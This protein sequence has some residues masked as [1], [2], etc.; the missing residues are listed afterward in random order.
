MENKKMSKQEQRVV[1]I[2]KNLPDPKNV[3]EFYELLAKY[4]FENI[5]KNTSTVIN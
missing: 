3:E 4:A 2:K 1:I 5:F